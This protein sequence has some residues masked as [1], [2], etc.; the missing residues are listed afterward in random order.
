MKSKFIALLGLVILASCK[1]NKE[2][3]QEKEV[4]KEFAVFGDSISNEKA[5][6]AAQMLA[7]YQTLKTGDTLA[8]KFT[9]KINEICQNKGCWMTLDLG[10]DQ[11]AFVKFKDY[12]FFVP[13]NAQN[14]EVVVEGKAFIEETPVAELKHYAEDEGKSKEAIDSIKTPKKELKFLAHGVLIAK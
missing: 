5:L 11:Q 3:V 10:Q 12:G 2:A 4:K 7:K 8:V 14:R 13:M 1:Q 9:T 6:T